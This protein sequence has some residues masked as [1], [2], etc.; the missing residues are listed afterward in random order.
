MAFKDTRDVLS[1][2]MKQLKQQG[3]G[4]FPNRCESVSEEEERVLWDKGILGS[5]NP[6]S[7]QNTIWWRNNFFGLRG[8]DEHR[9]LC[10]GDI[11]LETDVQGNRFLVY[12]ERETKTRKDYRHERDVVP[13]IYE[14]KENPDTC[15]VNLLLKFTHKRPINTLDDD[16]PFYLQCLPTHQMKDTIWYKAQPLGVNS[17]GRIMKTMAEKGGLP[18]KKTNHSGRKTTVKRLRE[19][20]FEA[21]DIMKITGHRNIQSINNYSDLPA[22]KHRKMSNV[23]TATTTTMDSDDD[24]LLVQATQEIEA[25]HTLR[26][27]NHRDDFEPLDVTQM[28]LVELSKTPDIQKPETM[29]ETRSDKRIDEFEPLDLTQVELDELFKV[30][31]HQQPMFQNCTFHGPIIIRKSS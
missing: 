11:K 12:Q 9:Q 24:D 18:G 22:E 5:D 29:S 1:T 23:L 2:K 14:T 30:T 7:L 17:L 6:V 15:P 3:K 31:D 27:N 13:K 25:L 10:W 28:E 4:R 19:A 21:I 20:Q 8:R 26:P 16:S